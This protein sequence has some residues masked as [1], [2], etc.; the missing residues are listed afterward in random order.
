[1]PTVRLRPEYFN[2][3]LPFEGSTHRFCDKYSLTMYARL[4]SQNSPDSSPAALTIAGTSPAALDAISSASLSFSAKPFSSLAS[5]AFL[6]RDIAS[7]RASFSRSLSFDDLT[8]SIVCLIVTEALACAE[9]WLLFVMFVA[10]LIVVRLAVFAVSQPL[11]LLTPSIVLLLSRF[12]D[13]VIRR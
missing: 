13:W 1:M 10:P 12:V 5:E 3:Q 9:L 6:N 8:T 11:I 7:S 2:G 4:A